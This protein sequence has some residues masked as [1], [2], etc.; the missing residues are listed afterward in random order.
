VRLCPVAHLGAGQPEDMTSV[1]PKPSARLRDQSGSGA[2]TLVEALVAVAVIGILAGLL[3]PLLAGGKQRARRTTCMSNL[4]QLGFAT[5]LHLDERGIW[6][7]HM[8]QLE[9]YAEPQSEQAQ[10]TRASPIWRCPSW[11]SSD[12]DPPGG[13]SDWSL[14]T[15]GSGPDATFGDPLGLAKLDSAG[16]TGRPEVDVVSPA[17]M[18]TISEMTEVVLHATPVHPL[19][20]NIPF[21][22]LRGY[23]L[24]FRHEQ[25]AN[26]LF[27]D[28]H[29][30]SEGHEKLIGPAEAV[31]RRWN[32][33]NLPHHRNWR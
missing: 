7:T 27:A 14:N 3:M 17:D 33:D 28:G 23:A 26:S 29:V 4:R 22:S 11:T 30:E 31:R 2:F 21:T 6:P 5:R 32:H 1:E 13:L 24:Q 20:T 8:M 18:I 12:F 16:M 15:W 10:R 19:W 9:T 25:R